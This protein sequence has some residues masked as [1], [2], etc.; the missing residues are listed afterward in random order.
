MTQWQP[1]NQPRHR[2]GQPPAT[3]PQ[4]GAPPPQGQDPWAPSAQGQQPQWV[5]LE[6][7]AHYG[8]PQAGRPAQQPPPYQP[9]R[10]APHP[11]PKK[12]RAGLF[13][14]LGC[15]GLG[16][17]VILIVV[18]TAGGSSSSPSAPAAGTQQTQSAAPAATKAAAA[19]T[20]T[21]EVAG[22]TADVTYGP[23]GTSLSGS[24]PLHVTKPLGT[25]LYYSISAQLQGGGDVSC[26]ILVDGK[27]ISSSEASGG[28]N[29]AQCEISPGFTG[30][31]QDTN[32]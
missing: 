28:Y 4:W 6:Q 5:P 7:R 3:P 25:P 23:A 19:Q 1:G 26:K 13:A 18:I 11:P 14:G 20:V 12:S 30:G 31:W 22:S 16:A 32:G 24:V 17:L 8:Q 29:I 15:G 2:A 21:Y 9:P 10:Y 27:V